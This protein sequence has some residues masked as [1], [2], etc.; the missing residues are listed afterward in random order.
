[1]LFAPLPSSELQPCYFEAFL[2]QWQPVVTDKITI[3]AGM[4]KSHL[5]ALVRDRISGR[6]FVVLGRGARARK[7]IEGLDPKPAWIWAGTDRE[8]MACYN[9]TPTGDPRMP[10]EP[11]TVVT[12]DDR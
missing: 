3:H 8:Y 2:A 12:R 9:P 10:F 11:V 6:P 4:S 5:A 7:L 1:M